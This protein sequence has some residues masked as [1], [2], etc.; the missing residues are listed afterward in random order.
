MTG[1]KH[2]IEVNG[3]RI[4]LDFGMHQGKREES[5]EKNKKL[6]IPANKVDA[7]ILSHGH[8]DHSGNLPILVKAGFKGPIYATH[9]TRD[10][11]SFMLLDS[12]F[13]QEREVEFLNKRFAK[14]KE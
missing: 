9:A 13:I 7:V 2:L 8:I 4:F 1:S 3:K 14:K 10:I 12:G 11:C 5:N 6:P